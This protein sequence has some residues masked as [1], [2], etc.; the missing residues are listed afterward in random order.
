MVACFVVVAGFAVDAREASASAKDGSL[1][2]D[3]AA[4]AGDAIELRA[5][6]RD[7]LRVQSKDE[8]FVIKLG[9]RIHSDWSVAFSDRE[10]REDYP[11]LSS[12]DSGTRLRR[13]RIGMAGTLYRNVFFRAEYDF[14]GGDAEPKD[15]YLGVQGI[16]WVG[17]IT[18]GHFKEPFSMESIASSNDITFLEPSLP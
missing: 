5:R 4:P 14:A 7:G 10:L 12:S 9:G 3:A 11:S 15:V 1:A 8:S 17:R 18:V 2:T 16:P 13:A 6:W